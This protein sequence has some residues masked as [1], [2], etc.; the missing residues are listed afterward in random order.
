MTIYEKEKTI[1][2][3]VGDKARSYYKGD[4]YSVYVKK[5]DRADLVTVDGWVVIA[6][7]LVTDNHVFYDSEGTEIPYNSAKDIAL[8]L[9]DFVDSSKGSAGGG[10][11]TFIELTDTP[12]SYAGMAGYFPYVNQEESGLEFTHPSFTEIKQTVNIDDAS[13]NDALVIGAGVNLIE[14]I[15]DA[16]MTV[17]WKPASV[18]GWVEGRAYM[19]EIVKNADVGVDMSDARA[20][21]SVGYDDD[22]DP[23][24]PLAYI[25]TTQKRAVIQAFGFKSGFGQF[26]RLIMTDSTYVE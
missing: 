26:G 23:F 8:I 24:P 7:F 14:V 6:S 11:S 19:F 17:D 16:A 5:P 13:A 3:M 15:L 22:I 25:D 4:L 1:I 21:G 20:A 9:A 10:S 12:E 2:I 18:T